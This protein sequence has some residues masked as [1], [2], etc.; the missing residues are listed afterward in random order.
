MA[1]HGSE[2]SV[3]GPQTRV[4]GRISGEGALRIEGTVRGDVAVNGPAEVAEGASIEGNVSAESLE[5][6]GTLLGDVSSQGPVAIRSGA[7]VR[8]EL[9]GSEISI[10]PGSRVS[11]RLDTE[12]ELDLGPGKRR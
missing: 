2:I 11:V 1:R 10:E 7:V 9:R 5:I 4:I 12:F 8:G 6:G 3:L